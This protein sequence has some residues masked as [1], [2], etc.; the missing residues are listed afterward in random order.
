MMALACAQDNLSPGAQGLPGIVPPAG[1][2]VTTVQPSNK[3]QNVPIG[4]ASTVFGLAAAF[5]AG[6]AGCAGPSPREA[7]P[8][9]RKLARVGLELESEEQARVPSAERGRWVPVRVIP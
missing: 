6:A 9:S 8:V 5:A 3:I 4:S 1:T 2:P 7:E